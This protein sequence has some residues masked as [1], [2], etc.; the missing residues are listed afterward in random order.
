[1]KDSISNP[2]S[3]T[4]R[5]DSWKRR[6]A[7]PAEFKSKQL[8][9]SACLTARSAITCRSTTFRHRSSHS[10]RDFFCRGFSAEDRILHRVV[11]PAA[12][13]ACRENVTRLE[14]VDQVMKVGLPVFVEHYV[15]EPDI[16][17]VCC[18]D[19]VTTVENAA[20]LQIAHRTFDHFVDI[21]LF[22]RPV[23]DF[24]V[25]R[26]CP[27]RRHGSGEVHG[28]PDTREDVLIFREIDPMLITDSRTI[29]AETDVQYGNRV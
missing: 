26:T 1:M 23:R 17:H 9:S 4:F 21:K 10:G 13:A 8:S 16:E 29:D 18:Q 2:T 19:A 22:M 12:V 11:V 14:I 15:C 6:S 25:H 3:K 5:S 27:L 24:D 20:L 7:E 28:E